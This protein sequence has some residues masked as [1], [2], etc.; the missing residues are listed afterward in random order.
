VGCRY[1]KGQASFFT[2]APIAGIG[3]LKGRAVGISHFGAFSDFVARHVLKKNRLQPIKDVA[4]IQ[5]GG[6]R[7]IIA[8]MQRNLL[9]GGSIC[10]AAEPSSARV[11]LSRIV[12]H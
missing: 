5:L 1:D 9:P 3:E 6:T 12:G 8:G 4:V 10:P 7:E 2:T 11:G